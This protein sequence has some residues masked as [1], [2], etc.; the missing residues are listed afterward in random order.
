MPGL[1]NFFSRTKLATAV[2]VKPVVLAIEI[3]LF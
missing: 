2:Q 3:V 1:V